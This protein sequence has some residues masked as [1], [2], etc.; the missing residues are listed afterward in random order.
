ME[1]LLKAIYTV[2][3]HA[4]NADHLYVYKH[5]AINKLMSEKKANKIGIQKLAPG[6]IFTIIEVCGFQFHMPVTPS[7]KKTLPSIPIEP[8]YRN[9][10]HHMSVKKAKKIIEEY[11]GEPL[12]LK[13]Y[14][15]SNKSN[16]RKNN[17]FLSTYLDGIKRY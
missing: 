10:K 7:D 6:S 2:N 5:R 13:R 1:E 8:Q 12:E 16:R 11:L 9:P 15:R 17:S 14:D 3:N 4:K